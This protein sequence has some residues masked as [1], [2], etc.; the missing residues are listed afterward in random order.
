[1]SDDEGAAAVHDAPPEEE[2]APPVKVP[3]IEVAQVADAIKFL[4][5]HK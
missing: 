4:R 5:D 2:E 3:R 1:M